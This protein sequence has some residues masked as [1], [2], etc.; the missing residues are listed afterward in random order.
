MNAKGN[1]SLVPVSILVNKKIT[2]VN[3]A[4]VCP[5]GNNKSRNY[6]TLQPDITAVLI[7]T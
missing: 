2:L 6:F 4:L 1:L 3:K 5:A 7:D